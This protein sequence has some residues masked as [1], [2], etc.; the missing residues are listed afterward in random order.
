MKGMEQRRPFRSNLF[1]TVA[2]S[3]ALLSFVA[4][5]YAMAY[6]SA[7]QVVYDMKGYRVRCVA[8]EVRIGHFWLA[9]A[10]ESVMIWQPVYIIHQAHGG[11]VGA[12]DILERLH[13]SPMRPDD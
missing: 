13:A 3:I 5:R 1:M 2:V 10:V 6:Y 8:D 12:P 4:V 9:A 11:Q 7:V